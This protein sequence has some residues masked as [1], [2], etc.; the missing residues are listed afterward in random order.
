MK[1]IYYLAFLVFAF[2]VSVTSCKKYESTAYE[3][4]ST[5]EKEKALLTANPWLRLTTL[6]NEDTIAFGDCDKDVI[7]TFLTDGTVL[8]HRD[9]N[10]CGGEINGS[11]TWSLSSDGK[12]LSIDDISWAIEITEDK[13]TLSMFH[14][15]DDSFDETIFIPL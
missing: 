2:T 13:L 9:A 7:Y 1:K 6:L 5:F 11:A 14:F 4:L 8:Y 12:T 3:G 15:D 10:N